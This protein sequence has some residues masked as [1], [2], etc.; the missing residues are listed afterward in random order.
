MKPCRDLNR[1]DTV[2]CSSKNILKS[3]R[4]TFLT[5]CS[6]IN[7]T[8]NLINDWFEKHSGPFPLPQIISTTND[9][10]G[11]D[12]LWD[13]M[14]RKEQLLSA[15]II[16]QSMENVAIAAGLDSPGDKPITSST[17]NI[18][19]EARVFRGEDNSAHDRVSLQAKG[20][21]MDI[22]RRTVTGGTTTGKSTG[23]LSGPSVALSK[24]LCR[25]TRFSQ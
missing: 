21:V 12:S 14:E 1:I 2:Q 8:I 16:L 23:D 7:S 17:E 25:L 24:H 22:Y 6:L 18:D 13:G 5:F 3:S 19:L 9:L 11:N 20:T 15:S 4:P 10:L